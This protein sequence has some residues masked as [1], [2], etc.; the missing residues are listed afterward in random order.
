MRE[1]ML[2]EKMKKSSIWHYCRSQI[3]LL[4]LI[5]RIYLKKLRIQNSV[6]SEQFMLWEISSVFTFK[7]PN[8]FKTILMY[9]LHSASN[10]VKHRFLGLVRLY[11]S[12]EQILVYFHRCSAS[13][14]AFNSLIKVFRHSMIDC[15]IKSTTNNSTKTIRYHL[16]LALKR[17]KNN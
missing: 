15:L 7:P 11:V 2:L 6:K 3:N 13:R 14:K 8:I 17:T 4:H 5:I 10:V 12:G 1:Q 16:K 9:H